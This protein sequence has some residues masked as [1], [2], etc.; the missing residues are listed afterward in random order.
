M[1]KSKRHWLISALII[2]YIY[3]VALCLLP[4]S[5]AQKALIKPV[6]PIINLFA[7]QQNFVT[8]APNPWSHSL[9][10]DA[11]VRFNDGTCTVWH[12]PRVET[13]SGT[14][15]IV[16]DRYRRLLYR[17]LH[18]EKMLWP[19]FAKYVARLSDSNNRH[20]ISV[21]LVKHQTPVMFPQPGGNAGQHGLTQDVSLFT[22]AV[23]PAD[24]VSAI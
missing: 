22:Y 21:E 23:Q 15:R 13:F 20:P 6:R 14:E 12:Y 8:Y 16:K 5:A 1:F 11:T 19:G 4:N 17:S 3:S 24:L 9:T 10:M 18:S 2:T 7:W